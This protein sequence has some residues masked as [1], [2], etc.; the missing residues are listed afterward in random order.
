[1]KTLSTLS[2]LLLTGSLAQ[3]QLVINSANFNSAVS[4]QALINLTS[5]INAPA[6]GANKTW[7]YHSAPQSGQATEVYSPNNTSYFPNS[8]CKQD[9]VMPLSV[10]N[11]PAT[12]FET[13]SSA[14]FSY[15]GMHIDRL[16]ISLE[17][18]TGDPNDSLI[19]LDQDAMT[20][21]D[22]WKIKT[23]VNFN[24]SSTR[25]YDMVLK[26]KITLIGFGLNNADMEYRIYSEEKDTVS[27]WGNVIL[28]VNG[29]NPSIPYQALLVQRANTQTDSFFVNGVPAPSSLLGP[30]NLTQGQTYK[31]YSSYLFGPSYKELAYVNHGADDNYAA[32]EEAHVD[33]SGI[34]SGLRP[35][36]VATSFALYPNPAVGNTLTLETA[37]HACT[38]ATL[39]DFSGRAITSFQLNGKD[40]KH[41]LQLPAGLAAGIYLLQ[42]TDN[43]TPL[44]TRSFVKP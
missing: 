38:G 7:D 36:D 6:T 10:L 41:T 21:G 30:F 40:S 18:Y 25:N 39:T 15:D 3:A 37:Q 4:N 43:G 13:A 17:P 27:G 31:S 2:V 42:L 34:I 35:V 16:S 23:P 28:P 8:N 1:M 5:N 24:T 29:S 9:V 22:N 14:G 12:L 32:I 44:G 26:F 20:N 19:V 33:G 11:I